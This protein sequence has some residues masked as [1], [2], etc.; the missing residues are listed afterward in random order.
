MQVDL[1]Q[2]RGE[3]APKTMKKEKA[4]KELKIERPRRAVVSEKE[5]LKRMK[6]FSKRKEQFLATARTGKGRVVLS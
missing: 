4:I 6:D 3:N 1:F 5:A 2:A